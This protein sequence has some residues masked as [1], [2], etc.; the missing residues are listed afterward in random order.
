MDPPTIKITITGKPGYDKWT[1]QQWI[2]EVKD[3][4]EE[5]YGVRIVVEEVDTG[6]ELPGLVVNDRPV[7]TGLPGEEGYLIEIL[8][9]ALEEIMEDWRRG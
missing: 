4:V 1:L 2:L 6:E 7:L 3:L 8:K 9:K 5:E